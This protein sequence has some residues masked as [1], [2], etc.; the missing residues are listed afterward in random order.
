MHLNII[1]PEPADQLNDFVA[2]I[3][4]TTTISIGNTYCSDKKNTAGHEPVNVISNR[5]EK[6]QVRE[7]IG[8]QQKLRC[9][10]RKKNHFHDA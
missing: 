2:E 7:V 8:G 9:G 5:R 10:L 6:D 3:K 4:R 1:S